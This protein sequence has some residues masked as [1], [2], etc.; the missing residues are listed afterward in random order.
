MTNDR[1]NA[2]PISRKAHSGVACHK[3]EI[4]L[5]MTKNKTRLRSAKPRQW[6]LVW[7]KL[8][9]SASAAA[10]QSAAAAAVLGRLLRCAA[11]ERELIRPATER[12]RAG[13][14]DLEIR[15]L[16]ESEFQRKLI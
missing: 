6:M 3:R 1:K 12:N 2:A 14:I 13:R 15:H 5:R 7:Q 8:I 4:G 16:Q 10:L 11:A 9:G